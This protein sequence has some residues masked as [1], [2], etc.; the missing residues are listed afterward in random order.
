MVVGAVRYVLQVMVGA[1]AWLA[2]AVAV[3]SGV[4]LAVAEM[5][6]VPEA[7]LAESAKR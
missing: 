7:A 2:V 4:H 5:D 6:R 3:L 1:F